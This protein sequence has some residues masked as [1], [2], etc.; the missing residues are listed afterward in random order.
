MDIKPLPFAI[1]LAVLAG[2][3]WIAALWLPTSLATLLQATCIIAALGLSFQVVFTLLGELS[4]GHSALFGAGAY[5]YGYLVL[6]GVSPF[7][8]LVAACVVGGATGLVVSSATARLGGAYFAVVTYALASVIA[9]IVSSTDALG[10]SEG[11]IGI[12][13]FDFID[14]GP[15]RVTQTLIVG[16]SLLIVLVAFY[17][18]WRSRFGSMLETVRSDANLAAAIGLNV[19]MAT[20]VATTISGVMAGFIGAVYAQNARFV[21][22][23]VFHLYY[24]VTPLAAVVIGGGRSL[25]GALL[26]AIV[27]VTLPM[28]M[29]FSPILNQVI[30]GSLM[31]VFAILFPG[32][33][34]ALLARVFRCKAVAA[35][36]AA[37]DPA[38]LPKI[39]SNIPA[40]ENV[41]EA[42]DISV[43]YAGVRA[44][45]HVSL[46][47]RAGEIL[48]LI[49]A[50]G[51]GKSSLVNAIAG[52]VKAAGGTIIS[53]K[54]PFSGKPAYARARQGL[55]RTFQDNAVVESL[56]VNQ[57]LDLASSRGRYL[58]SPE[59]LNHDERRQLVAACGLR[60]VADLRIGELSYMHRRLAALAIALAA[61]PTVLFLDEATAGL[62]AEERSAVGALVKAVARQ[63]NVAVL[64]IEHDVEFV[65]SISDRIMVMAEGKMLTEGK[66]ETVLHDPHV[67]ASY[68][69]SEWNAA[70]AV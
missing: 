9:V 55:A 49:G 44:V 6:Q 69:G 29:S 60:E 42:S 34:A 27:A 52:R 64:V 30:S 57:M 1:I 20:M 63:W 17:A 41:L 23:D 32:G 24:I 21:G 3:L 10:H 36:V 16:G 26:G 15:R 19:P 66:A 65:A 28:S 33:I 8:A 45:D 18:L 51:A 53:D 11:L 47:L 5:T 7:A 25:F 70:E 12:V 2:L 43:A 37:L 13:S 68:L 31:A 46:R 50:N 62:T 58:A 40:G 56:S 59:G 22:P 14:F 35:D 61:K 54:S 48:G 39:R 67:V 38:A 4:L